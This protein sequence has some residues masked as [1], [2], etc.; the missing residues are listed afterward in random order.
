ML[1]A[2]R[3]ERANKN[4]GIHEVL[5][6]RDLRN[7]IQ[8]RYSIDISSPIEFESDFDESNELDGYLLG[9]LIGDGSLRDGRVLLTNA[10]DEIWNS[11]EKIIPKYNCIRSSTSRESIIACPGQPNYIRRKLVEYGLLNVKSID[12][13]ILILVS[14][15]IVLKLTSAK[16][17]VKS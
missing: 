9:L 6:T 10:S 14:F 12:K 4:Y 5:T 17:L 13:L 2:K 11:V 16:L 7:N 8:N 3:R 15:S 1:S